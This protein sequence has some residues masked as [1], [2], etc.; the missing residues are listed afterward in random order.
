[1]SLVLRRKADALAQGFL[2]VRLVGLRWGHDHAGD[3]S[4]VSL[5]AGR[6]AAS[7]YDS[8][9]SENAGE[10]AMKTLQD[11]SLPPH[12]YQALKAAQEQITKE[13][14]VD[15]L[16]LFG[17]VARGTADEE[18]DVDLLIVL[19]ERPS[20]QVRNRISSIILGINLEYDANLSNLIVDQNAWDEGPLFVLPIYAEIQQQ[21]IRL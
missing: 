5:G 12:I 13:F 20:H 2:G 11:L 21:G 4:F 14:A 15:R 18:S 9:R 1:V 8:T 17:S 19:K 10:K 6:N 3:V 7:R 16:M